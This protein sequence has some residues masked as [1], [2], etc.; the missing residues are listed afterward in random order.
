MGSS[1]ATELITTLTPESMR[2]PAELVSTYGAMFF[3]KH[4]FSRL[5]TLTI[6]CL[7][8]K[9]G[10]DGRRQWDLKACS[11]WKLIK[12][13][14]RG[15]ASVFFSRDGLSTAWDDRQLET[16]YLKSDGQN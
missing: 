10:S 5:Y 14:E 13:F 12:Y 15:G 9:R 8:E 16:I 2:F 11:L 4:A 1:K 3:L 6:K 7:V